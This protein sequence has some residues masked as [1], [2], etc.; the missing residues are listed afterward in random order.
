MITREQLREYLPYAM[1]LIGNIGLAIIWVTG[2]RGI[3]IHSGLT[4]VIVVDVAAITLTM[5][6]YY[7]PKETPA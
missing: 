7:V 3:Y 1:I 5:Y 4:W 6:R 2:D